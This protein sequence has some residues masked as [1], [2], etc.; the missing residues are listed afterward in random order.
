MKKTTGL[1]ATLRKNKAKKNVTKIEDIVKRV[2]EEK[3]KR[4][5]IEMPESL[6]KKIKAKSVEM[7][8]SMKELMTNMI[9]DYLNL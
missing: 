4:L 7:G 6:H 5:I 9:E 3:K 8:V 2:H 1:G